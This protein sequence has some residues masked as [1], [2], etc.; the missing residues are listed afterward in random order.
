MIKD[1][2][3]SEYVNVPTNN[4]SSWCTY[5]NNNNNNNNNIICNSY[6]RRYLHVARTKTSYR[7]AVCYRTVRDIEP[8]DLDQNLWL[9]LVVYN[10]KSASF[11]QAPFFLYKG[12]VAYVIILG[13]STDKYHVICVTQYASTELSRHNGM[14]IACRPSASKLQ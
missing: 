4:I 14:P 3:G 11:S 12:I 5:N 2:F 10:W 1:V 13:K 8:V 7:E 9:L 6:F